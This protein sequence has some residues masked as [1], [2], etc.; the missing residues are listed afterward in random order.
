[1]CRESCGTAFAIQARWVI[2][3]EFAKARPAVRRTRYLSAARSPIFTMRSVHPFAQQS[4]HGAIAGLPAGNLEEPEGLRLIVFVKQ[5]VESGANPHSRVS[6]SSLRQRELS[7]RTGR[8][9]PSWARK[10]ACFAMS[11]ILVALEAAVRSL[12]HPA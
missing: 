9:A 6:S 7:A 4:R 5:G 11:R 2:Q 8:H 3:H 12:H 10:F 1:M